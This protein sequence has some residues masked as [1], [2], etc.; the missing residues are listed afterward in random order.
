LLGCGE[1]LSPL[2]NKERA[3][4]DFAPP[5]I[6]P[7][8]KHGSQPDQAIDE[9]SGRNKPESE[10]MLKGSIETAFYQD[11]LL[12]ASV[13]ALFKICSNSVGSS[14]L[15]IENRRGDDLHREG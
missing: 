15:K 5:G 6:F 4:T 13:S 7:R 14:E 11:S 12:T 2:N 9:Q 10:R 1:E 3:G 8:T